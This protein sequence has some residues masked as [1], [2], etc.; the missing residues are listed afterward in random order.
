MRFLINRTDA[1]GDLVV[2]LSLVER[3]LSRD[4][5][6]EIH[7]LVRE[8]TAPLLE[9]HPGIQAVHLRKDDSDLEAL[10]NLIRP[11]AVLNLS[12][13][14]RAFAV[15]A[16]RTGVPI[17]V[18]R[19]RGL[20]QIL[21]ATHL[22]WK[23]RYGTGRHEAQNTLDFLAPFGWEGG[24]PPPP[25]LY[26]SEPE[27]AHGRAELADHPQPRVGIVRKGSGAG[28]HPSDPWWD[29]LESVLRGTG[30]NPIVLAPAPA[31]ALPETH[32]RGLMARLAACDVVIS[33]STGPAHLSAAL[34]VPL[35][36]LMGRRGNHGPDR[37]APMGNRVQVVQYPGEEADLEGGMDRLAPE[38]LLPHLDR[39][40]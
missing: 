25:R 38:S 10:L 24:W 33:P 3:I 9:G 22:L 29:Q 1:I 34:G 32:L 35:L 30:W 18:S 31:S 26:L 16:K 19:A 20:D 5:L 14:D 4:P 37:W 6:A 15:A 36:V 12:H 40:K 27:R 21:S 17:R 11:D 23:G 13:R 39:L 28:A 8:A 2:S 7:L